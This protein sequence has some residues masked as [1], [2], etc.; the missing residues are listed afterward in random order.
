MIARGFLDG[1]DDSHSDSRTCLRRRCTTD[2]D[3]WRSVRIVRMRRLETRA[4]VTSPEDSPTGPAGRVYPPAMFGV[5]GLL[6]PTGR[7][8]RLSN[9]HSSSSRLATGRIDPLDSAVTDPSALRRSADPLTSLRDCSPPRRPRPF[10]ARSFLR[11]AI[12]TMTKIRVGHHRVRV[13][14][15]EPAPELPRL[16][17]DRGGG[18]LR[19]QPGPAG[20]RPPGLR[21]D[22]PT[23][24]LGGR[25][26]RAAAG[27]G[28]HRHPGFDPLPARHA[29]AWRRAST[30]WSRSRWPPP[31]ARRRPWP[32]WPTGSGGC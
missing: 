14:G 26:A 19:R 2:P 1:F 12:R 4:R 11:L 25:T 22:V 3:I 9:S 7:R 15:P 30:C 32:T 29:G 27:R 5:A 17:A 21:P 18:G 10:A 23:V 8:Y 24:A 20:G 31:S 28:R 13:L 6:Q 16:P